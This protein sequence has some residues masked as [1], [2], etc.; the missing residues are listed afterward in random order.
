MERLTKQSENTGCYITE[1]IDGTI[2]NEGYYGEAIEKL[3]KFENLY[4]HLYARRSA[5]PGELDALRKAGKEKTVTFR[6]LLG[7]KMVNDMLLT[8]IER[9]GLK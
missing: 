3:A 7:E 4:D 6:E 1:S 5:I 9:Q 2:E 8:Q